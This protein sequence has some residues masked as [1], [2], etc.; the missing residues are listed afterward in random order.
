MS[1]Y[2]ITRITHRDGTDRTDNLHAKRIGRRCELWRPPVRGKSLLADYR[3]SAGDDYAGLLR[4]SHVFAAAVTED[5]LM[6]TTA[7]SIYHFRL[8][9]GQI[10]LLDRIAE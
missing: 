1:I 4:T 9:A 10:S 8:A 7:D 5:G 6:V 2:T 3:P